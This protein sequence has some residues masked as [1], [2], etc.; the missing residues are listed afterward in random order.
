M[1]TIIVIPIPNEIS[2]PPRVPRAQPGRILFRG[3]IACQKIDS[4]TTQACIVSIAK[5]CP[6]GRCSVC[7]YPFRENLSDGVVD[8][9]LELLLEFSQICHVVGLAGATPKSSSLILRWSTWILHLSRGE[10]GPFEGRRRPPPP[11]VSVGRTYSHVTTLH[12]TPIYM[13]IQI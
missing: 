13:Y 8:V 5:G 1:N 10:H 12:R 9:P 4:N 2:C 7:R 6:L 11:H 3:L